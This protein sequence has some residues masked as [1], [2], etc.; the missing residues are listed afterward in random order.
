MN[1]LRLHELSDFECN[2]F[3]DLCD[4]YGVMVWQDALDSDLEANIRRVRHHACLA[5]W[6]CEE[7]SVIKRLKTEDPGRAILPVELFLRK[8]TLSVASF[9]EQRIV[10]AYLT[11]EERNLSHPT[12]VYHAEDTSI[13]M[14]VSSFAKHFLFPAHFESA[15][16]LSQIQ[17][18]VL[19]KREWEYVRCM[20]GDTKGFIHGRLN[21]F[22]PQCSTSTVDYEGRWKAAHYIL[23]KAMMPLWTTGLFSAKTQQ[24]ELFAFNDL[25]KPFKG[26][27]AWRLVRTQGELVAEGAK[28]VTL[29]PTTRDSLCEVSLSEFLNKY[30]VADLFLWLELKDEKGT[31]SASNVVYF[32]EPREWSLPHPRMRADIRVWDDNSYAVTLTSP[33]TVMW[34]WLSLEGM[35]ARYDDNYFCLEPGKPTRIRVTPSRRIKPEQFNQL[36]RI[37]S[38]RD[39]W[40]EKRTLMQMV[41]PQKKPAGKA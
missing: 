21:D 10:Q 7:A 17:Q 20:L 9:P 25:Q 16:W 37:G 31:V 39:T 19:L 12:C 22:W 3:Y 40:Q 6:G 26:E 41:V 1:L 35:D 34:V 18:G 4:E 5:I 36:I 29:A 28:A 11:E 38:L 13:P 23:R 33:F 32:C 2:A 15:L 14:M 27:L 30:G 24:V 8:E